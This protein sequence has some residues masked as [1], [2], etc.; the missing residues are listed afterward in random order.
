MLK[1]LLLLAAAVGIL[2]FPAFGEARSNRS[3]HSIT[4]NY[5]TKK[6]HESI[7]RDLSYQGKAYRPPRHI[8]YPKSSHSLGSTRYK[9]NETYK[10]S[11]LPKVDR[12]E[13][14]KR[15]FLRSKG[16]KRVPPGYEVDHII[17]LSKGGRN[18]PSNMQL[19]PKS[20]HKEK[21]ARGRKK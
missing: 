7:Y 20:L 10:S 13:S 15:E 11:G 17:P 9:H 6:P 8:T 16:H 18:E 14:A 3:P 12:S 1:R 2:L 19:I 5:G 4:Y 21:T